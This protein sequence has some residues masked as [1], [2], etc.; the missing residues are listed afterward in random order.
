MQAAEKARVICPPPAINASPQSVSATFASASSTEL[1]T[2]TS[3]CVY[4]MIRRRVIAI[5]YLP[6]RLS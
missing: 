3:L 1:T 4:S 2:H 6:V 5:L